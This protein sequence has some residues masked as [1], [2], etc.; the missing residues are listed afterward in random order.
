MPPTNDD[1][2]PL[3]NARISSFSRVIAMSSVTASDRSGEL[4]ACS[5]LILGGEHSVF[6]KCAVSDR[7]YF[8][9]IF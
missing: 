3:F 9:E 4:S 7:F 8:V 2:L 5:H 1:S 6:I